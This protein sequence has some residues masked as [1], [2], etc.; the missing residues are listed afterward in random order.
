MEWGIETR[1]L[2]ERRMTHEDG[3]VSMAKEEYHGDA[4]K[5]NFI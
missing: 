3:G 5:D 1:L 4:V 2:E